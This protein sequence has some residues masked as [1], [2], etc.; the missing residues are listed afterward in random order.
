M[1]VLALE[2]GEEIV[3]VVMPNGRHSLVQCAAFLALRQCPGTGLKIACT[4]DSGA[5]CL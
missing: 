4:A 3:R 2:M 1:K 5:V